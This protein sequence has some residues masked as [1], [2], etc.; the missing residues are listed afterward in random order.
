MSDP[1]IPVRT[2]I[3]VLR[4][5]NPEARFIG[6]SVYETLGRCF[7]DGRTTYHGT[8]DERL[9]MMLK[10]AASWARWRGLRRSF[11]RVCS[12]A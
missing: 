1:K 6:F 9:K 7:R 3:T 5:D 2:T 12:Q 8:N 10:D 4:N 11:R